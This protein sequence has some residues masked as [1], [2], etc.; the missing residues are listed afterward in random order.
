MAVTPLT[1]PTKP[2]IAGQTFRLATSR[3][4]NP[5]RDG[6]HQDIIM[7]AQLWSCE[8]STTELSKA[9]AGEYKWLA[10]IADDSDQTFYLYDA[11]RATPLNYPS[12]TGWGNPQVASVSYANGTISLT[13]LTAG[14]VIA[15]GDYGHWQDGPAR[16]LHILE[17][18]TA[19]GSGQLTTKVRPR[20]PQS[21][22][23][24]LP[25]AFTMLKASAEMKVMNLSAQF[26]GR[27]KTSQAS[28]TAVQVIRRY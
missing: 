7:S 18:G 19:N 26:D 12:G 28:L 23:A 24:S 16:R 25:V 1:L 21:V 14:A 6:S 17:G 2:K 4:F 22:T 20:P 13:G 11:E 5:A 8:I 10:A 9:I 3:A 15:K 27:Q